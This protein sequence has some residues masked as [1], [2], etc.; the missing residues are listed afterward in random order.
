MLSFMRVAGPNFSSLQ[1]C[2]CVLFLQLS[3]ANQA[4]AQL[5]FESE[6]INY[7]TAPGICG[8]R[9]LVDQM[10]NLLWR[11]RPQADGVLPKRNRGVGLW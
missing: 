4:P 5:D 1:W 9:L 6:P 7:D 2:F 11:A 8:C 3:I 10:R